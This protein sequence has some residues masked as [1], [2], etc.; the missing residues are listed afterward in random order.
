M[1]INFKLTKVDDALVDAIVVRAHANFGQHLGSRSETTM[2][3]IAC[4]NHACPLR[5]RELLDAK[6]FDFAHDVMGIYQHF[7]RATLCLD[8]GFLPRFA[9]LT[10][11]KPIDPDAQDGAAWV[12]R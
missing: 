3:L 9:D 7:N 6:P 2:D 10:K 8:S 5:L 1:N 12:N 11:F 4:H